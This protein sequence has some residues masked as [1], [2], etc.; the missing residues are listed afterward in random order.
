MQPNMDQGFEEQEA[1]PIAR[2]EDPYKNALNERLQQLLLSSKDINDAQAKIDRLVDDM[3][4]GREPDFT[5]IPEDLQMEA[6][7]EWNEKRNAFASFKEVQADAAVAL[8]QES[9]RKVED[10]ALQDTAEKA[11]RISKI[12]ATFGPV[13]APGERVSQRQ[14]LTQVT[15]RPAPPKKT[16][17]QGIMDRLRG[18]T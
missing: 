15:S 4:K 12:E 14:V 9:S 3:V 17:F 2:V 16:V 6:R 11:A 8:A 10:L 13:P 7:A 5:W 1:V 18:R